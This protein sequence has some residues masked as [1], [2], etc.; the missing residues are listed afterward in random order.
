MEEEE[1]GRTRGV[2]LPPA[3]PPGWQATPS[4]RR[5]ALC[6]EEGAQGWPH[7][8]GTVK[9]AFVTG[10]SPGARRRGLWFPG[11]QEEEEEEED[12]EEGGRRR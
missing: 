11:Q 12:G 2:W 4:T 5:P 1:D 3:I 10:L 8:A 9:A 6:G 7:P